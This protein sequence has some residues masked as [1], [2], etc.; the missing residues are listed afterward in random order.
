ME[1]DGTESFIVFIL[2]YLRTSE[3]KISGYHDVK[4][5][6]LHRDRE[7]FVVI[8]KDGG[9]VGNE[10]ANNFAAVPGEVVVEDYWEVSVGMRESERD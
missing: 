8:D 5:A 7:R 1:G 10:E 3:P 9:S 2:I 4:R 6:Y